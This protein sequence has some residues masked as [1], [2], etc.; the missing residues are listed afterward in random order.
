MDLKV[1]IAPGELIDKL[2]IL[3]IKQA[4]ISNATQLASV[5]KEYDILQEV[6]EQHLHGIDGLND[7]TSE[8]KKINEQLWIIEDDIRECERQQNFGPEFIQLARSVYKTNDV[9]SKIKRQINL[10]LNSDIIEE[11]SYQAY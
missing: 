9:R 7:L 4:N 6:C 11:K 3:E 10:L 5:R 1:N 2:T 8:L